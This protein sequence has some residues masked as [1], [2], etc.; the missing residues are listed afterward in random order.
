VQVKGSASGVPSTN[1]IRFIR[2]TTFG[3]RRTSCLTLQVKVKSYVAT[4]AQEVSLSFRLGVEPH[5]GLMTRHYLL[6]DNHDSV[7]VRRSFICVTVCSNV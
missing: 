6:L 5:L 1:S 2:D 7:H 3:S 4:E